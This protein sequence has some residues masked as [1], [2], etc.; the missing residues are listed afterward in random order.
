MQN[1]GHVADAG[2]ALAI[3]THACNGTGV[4]TIETF[5]VDGGGKQFNTFHGC[6]NVGDDFIHS[7]YEDNLLRSE[8]HGSD[9]IAGTVGIDQLTV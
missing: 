5:V 6:V 8:A 2:R 4:G 1:A 7:N 3:H 9:T